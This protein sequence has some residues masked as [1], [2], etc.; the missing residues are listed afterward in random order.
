MRQNDPMAWPVVT[1]FRVFSHVRRLQNLPH[2]NAA[3]EACRPPVSD[4]L[5]STAIWVGFPEIGLADIRAVLCGA[6]R[7]PVPPRQ[8]G[9]DVRL[10]TPTSGRGRPRQNKM[11]HPVFRPSQEIR[12]FS[13]R[14]SSAFWHG[15]C[16][17]TR[18]ERTFDKPLNKRKEVGYHVSGNSSLEL[19]T[20]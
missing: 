5:T 14:S 3:A 9:T 18:R 11:C 13:L 1:D 16:S 10:R 2:Q 20:V 6:C 12:V 4:F 15:L 17:L 19:G 8:T 7:L